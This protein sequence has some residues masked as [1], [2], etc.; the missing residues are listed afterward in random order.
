MFTKKCLRSPPLKSFGVYVLWTSKFAPR[1]FSMLCGNK[2]VFA[3]LET[4]LNH[5]KPGRAALLFGKP[6]NGKTLAVKLLAAEHG[7]ELIEMNGSEG[8]SKEE[9]MAKLA[10]A[11]AQASL[12][13]NKKYV[14]VDE[15]DTVGR[16]DRGGIAALVSLIKESPFPVLLTANR[17]TDARP[18]DVKAPRISNN[19][20]KFEVFSALQRACRAAGKET[21]E[22]IVWAVTYA[23]WA[24]IEKTG[25]LD[26]P[27]AALLGSDW[28][29]WNPKIAQLRSVCDLFRME[30]LTTTEVVGTLEEIAHHEKIK[31]ERGALEHL[32][33]VS[34][35][36]L[37]S[38]MLS[39]QAI[40]IGLPTV[41]LKD[42]E[43]IGDRDASRIVSEAV[44]ILLRTKE[45]EVAKQ[46]LQNL[47]VQ[48]KELLS[49]LSEN[50]PRF[51]SG[52]DLAN[53][54]EALARADVFYGRIRRRQDWGLLAFQK[55]A[56]TFGMATAKTKPNAGAAVNPLVRF[57][58]KGAKKRRLRTLIERKLFPQIHSTHA[59]REYGPLL[60]L[61]LKRDGALGKQ[62][63]LNEEEVE[64]LLA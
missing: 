15:V 22:K 49:W 58:A 56:L 7:A 55:D 46:A 8:R 40:A 30:P 31:C 64:F 17:V 62:L 16:K 2:D 18:L 42:A 12:F 37:R 36:D 29:E 3:R 44:T 11:T 45:P 19:P 14:L 28:W 43:V 26:K 48:D 27:L 1:K 24:E 21:P 60:K 47:D 52:D 53:A 57:S 39:F 13:G 59:V 10:Q 51:L 20:S 41:S 38:A 9:V 5:W 54:Y 63:R 50:I 25:K 23:N 61:L 35:G 33:S 6:G 34:G 4:W 32:A